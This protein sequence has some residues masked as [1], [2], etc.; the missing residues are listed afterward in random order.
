MNTFKLALIHFW[1]VYFYT[2]FYNIFPLGSFDI[3]D[4]EKLLD[5]IGSLK[6]SESKTQSNYSVPEAS[7]SINGNNVS[8]DDDAVFDNSRKLEPKIE[9]ETIIEVFSLMSLKIILLSCLY[10]STV[11]EVLF[12]HKQYMLI[13]RKR[14][15]H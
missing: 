8:N 5:E 2:C 7:N 1:C 4:V 6:E 11:Y 3:E 13:I 15:V 9:N 10:T 14:V 12:Q